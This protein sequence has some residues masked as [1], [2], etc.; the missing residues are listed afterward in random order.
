[1]YSIHPIPIGYYAAFCA[2]FMHNRTNVLDKCKAICYAIATVVAKGDAP[3]TTAQA[4]QKTQE[5]AKLRALALRPIFQ[6]IDKKS[7]NRTGFAKGLKLTK[8][9]LWNYEHGVCRAPHGFIDTC[10]RELGLAQ[11]AIP[12]EARALIERAPKRLAKGA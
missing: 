5:L 6:M 1:M 11:D 3:V 4:E 8:Y 12:Q 2:N 9:Q 7:I 10:I